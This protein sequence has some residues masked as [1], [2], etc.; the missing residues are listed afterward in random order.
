MEF[1]S[2][3]SYLPSD[4]LE[5]H[6]IKGMAWGVRRYQNEDGSLTAA[7]RARYGRGEAGAGVKR[8]SA[9]RMTKD[10]NRLDQGYANVAA[11][12]RYN[13]KKTAKLSRKAHK[14]ERQGNE[15]KKQKLLTKALKYGQKAALNNKQKKA[16]EALQWKIIGKAATQGYTTTSKAVKRTGMTGKGR[17]AL[18]VGRHFGA[19]GTSAALAIG[20]RGM[21]TVDGQKV[22]ISKRGNG[23]TQIVNYRQMNSPGV[24]KIWEEERNRELAKQF[25]GYRR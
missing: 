8:T 17:A 20:G 21:T 22:R 19:L 12:Q 4:V 14:A 7:G 15:A 6:G 18:A 13:A 11:D 24:Q 23:G 5:H 16:I 2:W 3:D 25:K 9:R 1:T 10:F